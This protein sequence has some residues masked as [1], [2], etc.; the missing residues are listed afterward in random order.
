MMGAEFAGNANA[1]AV[2]PTSNATPTVFASRISNSSRCQSGHN[3][4]RVLL[5]RPAPFSPCGSMAQQ[6]ICRLTGEKVHKEKG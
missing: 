6:I 3:L 1:S 2:E 5:F 4:F